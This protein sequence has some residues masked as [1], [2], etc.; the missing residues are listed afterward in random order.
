MSTGK[1]AFLQIVHTSP[2]QSGEKTA[3]LA[4]F[5]ENC[6]P[7]KRGNP[8]SRRRAFRRQRA[9]AGRQADK[10]LKRQGWKCF[11]GLS[12]ATPL[13]LSFSGRKRIRRGTVLQIAAA[14]AAAS[15]GGTSGACNRRE[16]SESRPA[17][18]EAAPLVRRAGIGQF[19]KASSSERI[20][21]RPLGARQFLHFDHSYIVRANISFAAR[22]KR[23]SAAN[24]QSGRRAFD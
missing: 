6:R 1:G 12:S 9:D 3:V 5:C 16:R 18:T 22:P 2:A 19:R 21:C 24:A 10:A 14:A 4:D 8:R 13:I 15:G 7:D 17:A 20:G 11:A 23:T